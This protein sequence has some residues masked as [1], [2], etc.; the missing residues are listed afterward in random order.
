[1]RV[2][3]GDEASCLNLNRAQAPRILGVAP[4]A[5]ALCAHTV[6]AYR[7]LTPGNWAPRTATWAV[8]NYAAAVRAVPAPAKLARLE[9]RLP[10]QEEDLL[11]AGLPRVHVT[12]RPDGPG[13]FLGAWLYDEAPDGSLTRIGWSY[14]NLR[15]AEGGRTAQDVVQLYAL[16]HVRPR[17]EVQGEPG[18]PVRARQAD[19]KEVLVNLLENARHAEP[20]NVVVRVAAGEAGE[21]RL[22]V[23]DDGRGIPA[24]VLSRVFE[25]TFS[26]TSSGSGLGLP[27]ARRLVESWGGTIE[28]TSREGRGTAVVITFGPGAGHP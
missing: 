24:D 10:A 26:T 15:Y 5:L 20:A 17:F 11:I 12:V 21:Q 2:R 18:P 14:M 19:V 8:Q 23:E 16:G 7:R 1:M 9:F 3:E 22:V 4:E 28:I 27:I 13:G 6:N 25:P